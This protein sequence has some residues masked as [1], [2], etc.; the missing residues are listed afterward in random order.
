MKASHLLIAATLALA[1]LASTV[2][3]QSTTTGAIQGTVSDAGTGDQLAGVTVTATSPALQGTQSAIT[4]ENG[5]YKISPLPP[6]LYQVTFYYLDNTVQRSNINVGINKTTPVFQK[7]EQNGVGGEIVHVDAPP[8]TID[9]TST[10]QGITIDKNYLRNVPVPGRTFEATL[11]AAAGSQGDQLGIAFSGSTSLENM[12]IVDGVNTTGL[13]VGTAGS[14]VITDFIEEIEVITGGYNA[15]FGRATGGVV[16]VVTKS[17][18]NEFRGSI[19]GTYKPGLLTYAAETTPVNAA[20][21]DAVGNNAYEADLGFNLGGPIK[22]DKLWFFV[23]FVPRLDST[24]ITR[25]TKRRTDC[26]V[27]DANGKLSGCDPRPMGAGGGNADGIPDVDPETG[28]YITDE[29]DSEVRK[30]TSRV[31]NAIGKINYALNPENQGQLSLQALPAHRRAEN[32]FGPAQNGFTV[33]SLV[34]DVAAKWTSKFNDNKTEVEG[35]VGW[36]RETVRTDPLDDSLANKPLQ[37]LARGNLYTWG[38]GFGSET[39]K[40]LAGCEDLTANDVYRGIDNC[41]MDTRPYLVGGPGSINDDREERRSA[42]LGVTQ[43]IKALGSHELKGGIDGEDNISVKS[44]QYSGGAFLQNFVSNQTVIVTRWVQLLGR[45]GTPSVDNPEPRFDN[46]CRTPDPNAGGVTGTGTLE[47]VCDYLSGVKDAPGTIVSGNTLNWG[48]YLRDSWQIQPNLTL[49]AGIRYEEQRLRYSS[50]LQNKVDPLTQEQLGT[51]AMTLTGNWAPRIGLLYDWTKEGRSKVYGH[52]GRFYESIPMKINDRSFGAEVQFQQQFSNAGQ[53]MQCGGGTDTA[54]GGPNGERCLDAANMNKTTPG[55]QLIGASGV[56]VMPGIRSQY[57]DE[58]IAG[59]EYELMDDLKIG[60]SY[61][62]RRLGR[63]IEDVST[64]GAQTY[65]IANPG[66]DL[67]S[68][69]EARLMDRIN[70]TDDMRE[71]ARLQNQLTLL[72]GIAIFDKPVR[73]YN[74]LQFTVSRRFSQKLYVQGSYTY[75]KTSGNYP[76]LISYDNGQVDPNISSQYDLIELL[77]NRIGP[78]PQDRPHAVKVDGY[79][80]FDLKKHGELTIGARARMT[81]GLPMNALAG[82]YLYGPNESML[83][84]RGQLGRTDLDHGLDLR[85]VYGRNLRR[86]MKLEVFADAY[87]IYNNQGQVRID[88]NYAPQFKLTDRNSMGG[89]EQN[90]NPVHGGTYQDL[91]WLKTIDRL[92][93]ETGE[94]IGRNPNFRNTAVRHAAGYLQLGA[95]LSF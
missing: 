84:P 71:K 43:R 88:E 1:G 81:S 2:R 70:R 47:F 94:P 35:V 85:V 19:F 41:I 29:L 77:G 25:T 31:F 37:V 63:V 51:N 5:F 76:G 62:N 45:V 15:E 23:G 65:I 36:H 74:A 10:S 17:G 53:M 46:T 93:N 60:V 66:E 67:S 90:A 59:F 6:G 78:L 24:D 95:R 58:F 34:T 21:I 27:V 72:K 20:S 83:L 26:R 82:H 8:P 7:I 44:R 38:R 89:D 33:D 40:T 30:D 61:Q 55:D 11:G 32:I 12:Y 52:W 42:R 50:G 9:P 57:L 75:S 48:A 79:Y 54:I 87:N 39:G 92:G 86:N 13:T 80:T 4:D 28:F 68:A 14:P 91:I 18:T 22:K 56:L 49:N 16:N 64:D 3:A 73:D 69:D